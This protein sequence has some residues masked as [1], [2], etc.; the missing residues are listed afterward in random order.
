MN[1]QT[2]K[3]FQVPLKYDPLVLGLHRKE[4]PNVQKEQKNNKQ[5]ENPQNT[6]SKTNTPTEKHRHEDEKASRSITSLTPT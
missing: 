4:T 2:H 3:M 5:T 1:E 6:K